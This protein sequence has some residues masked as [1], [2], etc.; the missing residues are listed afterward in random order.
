VP[1][2]PDVAALLGDPTFLAALI[3]ALVGAL[4]GGFF[5][6]G[7]TFWAHKLE[8]RAAAAEAERDALLAFLEWSESRQELWNDAGREW[9]RLEAARDAGDSRIDRQAYKAWLTKH[10]PF[11]ALDAGVYRVRVEL[12]ARHAAVAPFVNVA[13]ALVQAKLWLDKEPERAAARARWAYIFMDVAR[14]IARAVLLGQQE[15]VGQYVKQL[16]SHRE[17]SAAEERPPW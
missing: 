1:L 9:V 5:T 16:E 2:V 14:E 3:G 15:T 13:V 6:L 10:D 17:N 8:A 12:F 4:V 11:D 7:G